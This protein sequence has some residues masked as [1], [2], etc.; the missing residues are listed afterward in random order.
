MGSHLLE[1]INKNID[2]Q[3]NYIEF[4]LLDTNFSTFAKYISGKTVEAK[5]CFNGEEVSFSALYELLTKLSYINSRLIEYEDDISAYSQNAISEQIV[6]ERLEY[7]YSFR[8]KIKAELAVTSE[9]MKWFVDRTLDIRKR[10][11]IIEN[12]LHFLAFKKIESKLILDNIVLLTLHSTSKLA[13]TKT[14]KKIIDHFTEG[15]GHSEPVFRTTSILS[16][17]SISDDLNVFKGLRNIEISSVIGD[18]TTLE[19]PIS[20]EFDSENTPPQSGTVTT[21]FRTFTISLLG[22]DIVFSNSIVTL[23]T[24]MI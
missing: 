24:L 19:V 1:I 5:D 16:I 21:N 22:I 3:K 20:F 4:E 14:T 8:E 11:I 9:I 7:P 10:M 12:T 23:D 2:F 18:S 15:N 6:F 13:V 17:Y